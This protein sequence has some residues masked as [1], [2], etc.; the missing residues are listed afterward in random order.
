MNKDEIVQEINT[1]HEADL[2]WRVG[3]VREWLRPGDKKT[4][5]EQITALCHYQDELI[6]IL[7]KELVDLRIRETVTRSEFYPM[8][9]SPKKRY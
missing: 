8:S 2:L 3:E 5:I 1:L 9:C 6:M 7:Q 4:A